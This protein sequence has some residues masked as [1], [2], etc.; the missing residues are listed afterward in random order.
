MKRRRRK[1]CETLNCASSFSLRFFTCTILKINLNLIVTTVEGSN[2]REDSELV[3][4]N[5]GDVRRGESLPLLAER[6]EGEEDGGR[7]FL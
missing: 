1:R 4:P 2:T 3:K 5:V 7:A 6:G